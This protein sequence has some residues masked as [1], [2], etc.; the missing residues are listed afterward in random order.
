MEDAKFDDKPVAL[1]DLDGTLADFDGA[2]RSK[3]VEITSPEEM[4]FVLSKMNR[5][6][7]PDYVKARRR[8]IKSLPG[9]WSGLQPRP[10]GFAVLSALRELDFAIHVLTN[11]PKK[12]STAWKEKVDWCDRYVPDLPVQIG[13]EKGLVY[14]RVLVDDW[15]KYVTNWLAHRPRGTVIMPAHPWNADFKHPNVVRYDGNNY[16]EV[17]GALSKARK[18]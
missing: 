9:F 6:D 18:R 11:G 16:D 7:E 12:N 2:M 10:K 17:V 3:M 5:D 15:P 8:M 13:R 14:G 1:V 4:E